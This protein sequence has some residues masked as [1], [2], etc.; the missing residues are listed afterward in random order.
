M[1][2]WVYLAPFSA[3]FYSALRKIDGSPWHL[4]ASQVILNFPLIFSEGFKTT[5]LIV[6]TVAIWRFHGGYGI[7][8]REEAFVELP[9][10]SGFHLNYHFPL[11]F[12]KVVSLLGFIHINI[13]VT[14]TIFMMLH[15]SCIMEQYPVSRKKLHCVGVDYLAFPK[16]YRLSNPKGYWER[17]LFLLY[18]LC[19]V[20]LLWR[21]SQWRT[22]STLIPL[23]ISPSI[24]FVC[25]TFVACSSTLPIIMAIADNQQLSKGIKLTRST[26]RE[27]WTC[28][29]Q[30]RSC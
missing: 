2:A 8:L 30:A 4:P 21:A 10:V 14:C 29:N 18:I 13:L 17:L 20:V 3:Y 19:M 5:V 1:E 23:Y 11:R 16:V 6:I 24:A 28:A 25:D 26:E 22:A 9:T 27:I 12:Q 7:S 15:F